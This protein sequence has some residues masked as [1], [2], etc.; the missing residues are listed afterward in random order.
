MRHRR[1]ACHRPTYHSVRRRFQ[2]TLA[3]PFRPVFSQARRYSNRQSFLLSPGFSTTL[4]GITNFCRA[5]LGRSAQNNLA[6]TV[7][8]MMPVQLAARILDCA[9]S[10]PEKIPLRVSKNSCYHIALLK[11]ILIVTKKQ[12][13]ILLSDV[14]LFN[15]QFVTALPAP[16]MCALL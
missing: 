9:L 2:I 1:S 13:A 8:H 15:L 4:H 5:H 3:T 10:A 6:C 7:K 14:E 12:L 11:T 16:T